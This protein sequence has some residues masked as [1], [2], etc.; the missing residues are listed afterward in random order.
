MMTKPYWKGTFQGT[1]Q[2]WRSWIAD[3]NIRGTWIDE[4]FGVKM[5]R[6]SNGAQIHW[7]STKMTVWVSGRP[8]AKWRIEAQLKF[9]L[10][11]EEDDY[12]DYDVLD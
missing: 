11:V 6:C 10:I 2:C 12:P 1:E 8:Q 5:L 4:P 3:Q 9:A 7:S